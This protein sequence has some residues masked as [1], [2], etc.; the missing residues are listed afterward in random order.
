MEDYKDWILAGKIAAEVREYSKNLIHPGEK[1]IDIAEKI[2]GKIKEL[3]AQPAF[4]VNLSMNETA[5][6][7]TP[8]TGDKIILNDELLKVDIGTSVNGA[9]GDTAY[10]IDLSGKYSDLV[11]ASAE[12]VDNAA[13]IIQIGTSL[14]EIGKT[15]QETI[16]SHGFSPVKNLSGHGLLRYGIHGS[17]QIPNYDTHDRTELKEGMLIAVEPFATTG[18]GLIKESSSPMIYSQAGRNPVRDF[19]AR[20]ILDDISAYKDL[21]FA[22]RWLTGKYS[23][24]RLMLAIRSLSLAGNLRSYPPLVEV[25]KGLVSQAEHSFLVDDKVIILTN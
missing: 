14:G 21:P 1:L 8:V 7:Y 18:I 17:P 19:T 12:A 13:K 10:T 25:N 6:H 4:P 5:A 22:T 23:E 3:G 9:I 16:Q 15:I 20:K 2:E 11:K 24:A